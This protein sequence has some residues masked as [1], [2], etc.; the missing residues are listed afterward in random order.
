[1]WIELNSQKIRIG[2][3]SLIIHVKNY[4]HL[5]IKNPCKNVFIKSQK[6][7]HFICILGK[8]YM[9]LARKKKKKPRSI[10]TTGG[11][12]ITWFFFPYSLILNFS[13]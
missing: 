10:N 5:K 12:V 4:K 3:L 9:Y 6:V 2:K 11:D 7:Y 8:K 13:R 1:M